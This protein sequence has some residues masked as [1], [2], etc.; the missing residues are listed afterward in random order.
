LGLDSE[1]IETDNEPAKIIRE[2]AAEQLAL[3]DFAWEWPS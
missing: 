1:A 2:R 3:F